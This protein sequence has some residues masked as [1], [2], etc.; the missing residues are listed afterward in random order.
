MPKQIAVNVSADHLKSLATVA[1]PFAAISEL[2]WNGLDADAKRVQVRFDRNALDTIERIRVLDDGNGIVYDEAD[3]HFGN[4]GDSWKRTKNRTAAGRGM[5]GKSGKG[6]FRAFALGNRVTWITSAIRPTGKL[7]TCQIRGDL[8]S[9]KSFSVSDPDERNGSTRPGTE[10]VVEN[11]H[12]EFGSL[13]A[14]DAPL[15]A[16]RERGTWR[17]RPDVGRAFQQPPMRAAPSNQGSSETHLWILF[18]LSRN[19]A[20]CRQWRSAQTTRGS[21]FSDRASLVADGCR[22]FWSERRCA[23][24]PAKPICGTEAGAA[25]SSRNHSA[26]RTGFYPVVTWRRSAMNVESIYQFQ[27]DDAFATQFSAK[28]YETFIAMPFS[29]RGSYPEPRIKK[30]LIE[31]VHTRANALSIRG[32]RKF[33]PLHRVDGGSAAGAVT[34]TDKFVTDILTAHF[35]VGD[36]TG[37]NFGVVLETGI[38]LALKPND[39]VLLF[40]QDDTASL[41]FDLKV[42][43]VNRYNEDNLVE[44]VA[45]ALVGAARDFECEADRY[46]RLLSS[47]LTPDGISALNIYGR[48]WRIGSERKTGHHSG[49]IL[50]QHTR[51]DFSIGSERSRSTRPSGS[52]QHAG[53]CGQITNQTPRTGEMLTA[54]M[55]QN[56]G[57][58]SLNISGTMT[59]ECASHRTLRTDQRSADH[60]SMKPL[61]PYPG[62]GF[63]H[64]ENFKRYLQKK[65]LISTAQYISTLNRAA[66]LLEEQLNPKSLFNV[67]S[68]RQIV[69]RIRGKD[70]GKLN[71]AQVQTAMQR[72]A[73]MVADNFEDQFSPRTTAVDDNIETATATETNGAELA[74]GQRALDTPVDEIPIRVQIAVSRIVRNTAIVTKI[75]ALYDD[76]CQLCGETLQLF[77]TQ[78]YSEGHHLMP[79]GQPHNG[80][81]REENVMCVCPN[82]HVLLDYGARRINLQTLKLKKHKIHQDYV[83]YHNGLCAKRGD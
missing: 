46:V 41:H 65:G 34:I 20:Q 40:T 54:C 83:N 27:R 24:Y 49:K 30:L 45:R 62:P 9:L 47:Q 72:Y 80:A 4:L 58:S 79:L 11:L 17:T 48:L 10:V 52:C 28:T 22:I 19:P 70:Y 81:D 6:R 77:E 43:N 78:R 61:P 60:R 42:T 56:S 37:C 75:K 38:A 3:R 67:A 82:C 50:R 33:S 64:Q 74:I 1:R 16:V 63:S 26:S 5:H 25:R 2:V 57:G 36:L 12:K 71:L 15:I 39:R 31:R 35:F 29:N 68:V 53:W 18:R 59:G 23:R 55:P 32:A 69:A 7:A 76:Q 73:E 21:G 44:K 66:K 51:P 8:A 14:D 13:T